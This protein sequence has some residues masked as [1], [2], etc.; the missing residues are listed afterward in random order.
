MKELKRN[1]IGDSDID[2]SFKSTNDNCLDHVIKNGGCNNIQLILQ[3][4]DTVQFQKNDGLANN[5]MDGYETCMDASLS[6]NNTN[7]EISKVTTLQIVEN[8]INV[9]TSGVDYCDMYDVTPTNSKLSNK[10]Q[11]YQN[12]PISCA[13]KHVPSSSEPCLP[14]EFFLNS[15]HICLDSKLEVLKSYD[16]Q[17]NEDVCVGDEFFLVQYPTNHP[18]EVYK[19]VSEPNVLENAISVTNKLTYKLREYYDYENCLETY[20]D[21]TIYE[22]IETEMSDSKIFN[23]IFLP[24]K[25]RSAPDVM[26]RSFVMLTYDPGP[27]YGRRKSAFVAGYAN[28]ER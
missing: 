15:K 21:I 7:V 1:S 8:N 23:D 11:F 19:S 2:I 12:S 24:F 22:K 14:T 26:D 18:K 25:S 5:E 6:E 13:K 17:V 27:G 28:N 3:N 20:K 9:E 4:H 10:N 16:N